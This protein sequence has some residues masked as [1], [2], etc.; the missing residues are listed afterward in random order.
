MFSQQVS[1]QLSLTDFPIELKFTR[2]ISIFVCRSTKFALLL[3][4]YGYAMVMQLDQDHISCNF[5][6]DKKLWRKS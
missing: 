4:S 2:A 5:F 6:R 3:C 1:I